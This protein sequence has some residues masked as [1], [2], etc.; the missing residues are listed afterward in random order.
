MWEINSVAPFLF[1]VCETQK[2]SQNPKYL[3]KN[4]V[5]CRQEEL[6]IQFGHYSYLEYSIILLHLKNLNMKSIRQVIM[7]SCYITQKQRQLK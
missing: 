7:G 5:V 3:V 1:Q 2:I 4:K 6:V